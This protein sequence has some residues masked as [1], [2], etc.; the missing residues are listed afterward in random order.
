MSCLLPQF[1]CLPDIFALS[2]KTHQHSAPHLLK[3]RDPCQLRTQCVLSTTSPSTSTVTTTVLDIE[4]LQ[5]PSI[6]VLSN[7]VA[8][9]R[10]WNPP[11]ETATT[12]VVDIQKLK[13][14]SL[15]AHS[16]S[17][18]PESPWRHSGVVLSTEVG[19]K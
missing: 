7:S 11:S 2:F 5:L 13:L 17:V 9:D 14:Q 6:T 4:K 19:L 16:D 12:T 3:G 18:A 10:S 1:K 15:E 8:A